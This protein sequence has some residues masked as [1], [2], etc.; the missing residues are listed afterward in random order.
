MKQ[1]ENLPTLEKLG[2]NI[3]S[4]NEKVAPKPKAAPQGYS[5]AMRMG[6]ELISGAAVG[7]ML[8]FYID[9]WLGT[10]PVV[11]I[12]FFFLGSAG[13]FLTLIRT[14]NASNS[15]DK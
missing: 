15:E 7:G 6:V 1:E 2:E 4:L 11:F 3:R 5:L 9:K 13:G 8:G 14:Y 10:S 12:L